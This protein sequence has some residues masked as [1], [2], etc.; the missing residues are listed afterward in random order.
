MEREVL[1][2]PA[3]ARCQ[4]LRERVARA[5]ARPHGMGL[6]RLLGLLGLTGALCLA[7]VAVSRSRPRGPAPEPIVTQSHR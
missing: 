3:V 6:L 5:A 4:S 7:G 2:N 1:M